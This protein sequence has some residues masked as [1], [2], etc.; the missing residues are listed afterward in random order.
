MSKTK[1]HITLLLDASGS[2]R[3]MRSDVVDGINSFIEQQKETEGKCRV[4]V[5]SFEGQH[6][7]S[8]IRD[9]VKLSNWEPVGQDEYR[10]GGATP[11]LDSTAEAILRV[12]DSDWSQVFVT[13]TDGEENS[14]RE[15]TKA[16]VKA[17]IDEREDWVFTYLGAAQ[18]AYAEAGSYGLAAGNIQNFAKDSKGY[19][20]AF[21]SA[22]ALVGAVRSARSKGVDFDSLNAYEDLGLK[23]EAE[24]TVSS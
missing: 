7:L 2:M 11:L 1:T 15:H 20:T 19:K 8:V 21:V 18:D 12:G 6:G 24:E 17:M 9:N 3:S 4:S 14:S 22:G 5:L 23:K 13:F 16:D 10:I